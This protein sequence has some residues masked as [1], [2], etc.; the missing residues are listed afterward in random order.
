MTTKEAV[1]QEIHNIPDSICDEIL[2]F[3]RFLKL[4]SKIQRNE[5]F[6]LSEKSLAKEWLTP[7]EDEA[8]QSL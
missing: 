6:L 2:D 5:S 4:K 7:E 3:I 8:W 1:I